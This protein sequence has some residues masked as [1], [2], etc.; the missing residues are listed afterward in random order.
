MRCGAGCAIYFAV[1][2]PTQLFVKYFLYRTARLD[3][4]S[5][6]VLH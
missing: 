6:R 2:P 4:A 1:P 5:P 3:D